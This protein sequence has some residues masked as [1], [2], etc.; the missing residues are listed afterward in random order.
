MN[1]AAPSLCYFDVFPFS[2]HTNKVCARV[3]ISHY[4]TPGKGARGGLLLLLLV[5]K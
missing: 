4:I 1:I 3:L 2:S 5:E